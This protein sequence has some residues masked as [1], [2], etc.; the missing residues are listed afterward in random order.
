LAIARVAGNP[1]PDG[2]IF[3]VTV[4][5]MPEDLRGIRDVLRELAP[6]AVVMEDVGGSRPGNGARSAR[7]FAE[8]VG[9]LKMA[10]VC[11]DIPYTL[12]LPRKWLSGLFGPGGYP[13]GLGT[14]AE[15]KQFV[16]ERM[17]RQWP[18]VKFT[19]RQADAL[20]ILTW[21]LT[22][23]APGFTLAQVP[24]VTLE[25]IVQN[26]LGGVHE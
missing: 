5:N 1:G 23:M 15:R 2:A 6:V 17:D 3:S 24:L 25:P 20:A 10:L 13:S 16:K 19:K 21:G 14:E 12:V 22:G 4:V 8:H 11:L 18:T 26:V 9:A 7:T